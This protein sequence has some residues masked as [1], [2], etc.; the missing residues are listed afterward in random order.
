[1]WGIVVWSITIEPQ[2]GPFNSLPKLSSVY[3]NSR[4]NTHTR[5]HNEFEKKLSEHIP[6]Y[7]R[8]ITFCI[9]R[10][11]NGCFVFVSVLLSLSCSFLCHHPP[12][13]AI[14]IECQEFHKSWEHNKSDCKSISKQAGTSFAVGACSISVFGI[15]I[16]MNFLLAVV[17][18]TAVTAPLWYL[19]I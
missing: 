18:V 4:V 16:F 12:F 17:A 13:L 14:R 9:E 8:H 3:K 6:T 2:E 15:R 11:R 10:A 19:Y 1:M 5:T 7:L